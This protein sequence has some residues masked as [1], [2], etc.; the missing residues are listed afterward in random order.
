MEN[1]TGTRAGLVVRMC[2]ESSAQSV[3]QDRQA[4]RLH[5]VKP[6][7]CSHPTPSCQQRHEVLT[8]K[9]KTP[10]S[11]LVVLISMALVMLDPAMV[12]PC[13]YNAL[14]ASSNSQQSDVWSFRKLGYLSLGVLTIRILL[15]GGTILGSPIFGNPH[16]IAT[17]VKVLQKAQRTGTRKYQYRHD[18]NIDNVIMRDYWSTY[19]FV[20]G[21]VLLEILP[22][23]PDFT[24]TPV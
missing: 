23:F 15:F 9:F 17:G 14:A 18:T 22:H 12:F 11:A 1:S 13:P 5:R 6:Y 21:S 10:S 20:A 3:C 7:S 16:V 24:H 4:I 8:N 2:L 19:D